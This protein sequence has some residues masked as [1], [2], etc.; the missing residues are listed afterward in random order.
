MRLYLSE[1]YAGGE[2]HRQRRNSGRKKPGGLGPAVESNRSEGVGDYF[3]V[4]DD[5]ERGAGWGDV[6][7]LAVHDDCNHANNEDGVRS[8]NVDNHVWILQLESVERGE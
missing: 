8:A 3:V 2:A 5:P 7:R 4:L 1:E 6:A